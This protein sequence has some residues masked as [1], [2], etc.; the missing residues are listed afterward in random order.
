MPYN[1]II[2]LTHL[3]HLIPCLLA[4]AAVDR[5]V[6]L[7]EEELPRDTFLKISDDFDS[8]VI[9]PYTCISLYVAYHCMLHTVFCNK[10]RNNLDIIQVSTLSMYII[11]G[12]GDAGMDRGSMPDK[13][14]PTRTSGD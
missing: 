13:G 12:A 5:A 6:E 1:L 7:L 14:L 10:A 4:E 2:S 9:M 8:P 3:V 11:M